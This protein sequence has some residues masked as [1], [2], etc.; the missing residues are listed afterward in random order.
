MFPCIADQAE[1]ER[2]VVD[3]RYLHRQQLLRLEQMVEISFRVNPVR[4]AAAGVYGAE[5]VLPLL[6]EHIHRAVVCEQHRVPAV[7]CGHHAIEHIHAAGYAFE[8]VLRRSDPHQISR[9]VLRENI[10]DRLNH[11]VHHFHRFADSQSADSVTVRI[12]ISHVLCSFNSEVSVLASLHYREQ[13]L[14]VAI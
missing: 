11:L 10:V 4:L 6:V 1:V 7:T 2:E 8:D 3:G 13:T 5:I 14:V 12:Y 9:L